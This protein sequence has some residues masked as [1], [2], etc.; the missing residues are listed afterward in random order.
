MN[1]RDDDRVS[2]VALVVESD[3]P[4]SAAV[5]GDAIAGIDADVDGGSPDAIEG[6]AEGFDA[7]AEGSDLDAEDAQDASS[8]GNSPDGD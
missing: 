2:A 3:A 6:E 1:V 5:A 7:D 8:D 4:T